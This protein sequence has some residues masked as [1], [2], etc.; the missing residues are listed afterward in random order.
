[1]HIPEKTPEEIRAIKNVYITMIILFILITLF[2]VTFLSSCQCLPEIAND[3]EK[4]ADNDAITIN[5][6]KDCFQRDT[7]VEVSIKVL[8]KAKQVIP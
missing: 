6:N 8:N 1:M 2:G 5:C 4:I 7:D 3:I